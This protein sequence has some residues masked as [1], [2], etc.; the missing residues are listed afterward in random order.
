MP[1]SHKIAH[2]HG[3]DWEIIATYNDEYARLFIDN[4]HISFVNTI[5]THLNGTHVDYA[6]QEI[7]RNLAKFLSPKLL[8]SGKNKSSNET[9]RDL[10]SKLQKH[11]RIFV[12]ASISEPIF[13]SH[14]R[15]HLVMQKRELWCNKELNEILGNQNFIRELSETGIVEQT[16]E[17]ITRAQPSHCII[18][19]NKCN[20]KYIHSDKISVKICGICKTVDCCVNR[21]KTCSSIECE[22]FICIECCQSKFSSSLFLCTPCITETGQYDILLLGENFKPGSKGEQDAKI[23]FELALKNQNSMVSH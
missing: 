7:A 16:I 18:Q 9:P 10:I 3:T 14:S 4:S 15:E 5:T 11:L 19:C 22:N 2:I 8:V 21:F 20:K 17:E 13:D 1:D 6:S 12:K 23:E